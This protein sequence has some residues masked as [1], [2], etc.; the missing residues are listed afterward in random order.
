M[1]GVDKMETEGNSQEGKMNNLEGGGIE[2]L[3][4][5][6]RIMVLDLGRSE[7]VM[8]SRRENRGKYEIGGK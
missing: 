1:H 3:A 2:G 7:V 8:N 5:V 6:E 4:R